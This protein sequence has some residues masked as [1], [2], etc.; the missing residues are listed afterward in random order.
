[1]Y[2]HD[3]SHGKGAV[4]S[5]GMSNLQRGLRLAVTTAALAGCGLLG[6]DEEL[7]VARI[8][9]DYWDDPVEVPE[10]ARP[11]V[12]F[13]V[14]IRTTGGGCTQKGH[15]EVLHGSRGVVLT[16]YD[17]ERLSGNC[18][19]ILQWFEHRV[20]VTFQEPGTRWIVIR[21]RDPHG[22]PLELERPVIVLE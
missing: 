4:G 16:P 13:D 8:A 20:S 15:T 2:R 6:P 11:G 21:A 19:D 22:A 9:L 18:H 1:M 12:S 7:V 5:A 3:G 14:L 17:R 10:M